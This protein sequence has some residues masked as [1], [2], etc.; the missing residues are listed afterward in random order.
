MMTKRNSKTT[1]VPVLREY[2]VPVRRQ[3]K[4]KDETQGIQM[5]RTQPA[6]KGF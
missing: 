1:A 5:D 6:L 3:A 4:D 2:P